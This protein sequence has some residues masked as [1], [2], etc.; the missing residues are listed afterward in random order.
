MTKRLL[1]V[2]D[3]T[4]VVRFLETYLGAEGYEVES[5]PDGLQGLLKLKVFHPDLA[6]VD[7]MM[8]DVGGMRLLE[9]L[10]EE[11]GDELPVPVV[12]ITGW[13]DGAAKCR[14]FLPPED[15]LEKPFE[16]EQL[17]ARIRIHLGEETP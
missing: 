11:G 7:L 8:P 1:V 10:F 15:V 4:S 12:V 13:P 9:Q 6:I 3:D 5:A 16:P 2:E 17:L 14:R